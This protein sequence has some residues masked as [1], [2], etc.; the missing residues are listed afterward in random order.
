M[1]AQVGNTRLAGDAA[2]R[3]RA[4]A[5]EGIRMR[6]AA[7]SRSGQGGGGGNPAVLGEETN[8]SPNLVA[9]QEAFAANPQQVT[10]FEQAGVQFA[11]GLEANPPQRPGGGRLGNIELQLGGK[12]SPAYEQMMERIRGLNAMKNT[13]SRF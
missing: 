5:S 10:P 11:P 8:N 6:R 3:Q 7:L 9:R 2:A 12:G 13:G 1:G 4:A